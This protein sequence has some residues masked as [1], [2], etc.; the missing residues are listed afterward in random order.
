MSDQAAKIAQLRALLNT[1]GVISGDAFRSRHAEVQEE[2]AEG[3]FEI[4]R[5]VHGERVGA[6][7]LPGERK[8]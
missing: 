4:D 6:R 7:T 5:V 8:R 2:R 1:P 3:A